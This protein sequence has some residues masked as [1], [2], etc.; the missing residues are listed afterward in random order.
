[1]NKQI[2]IITLNVPYPPDYG[3]IIDTF[4][5]IK[6]L[7][8]IGISIHLHCFEYGRG[9]SKELGEICETVN[10]YKRRPS[11]LSTWTFLPEI[12]KSRKSNKLLYNLI[13]D[14]HPILFD[15]LHTT[16][17]LNHPWL[18]DRKK[19][20]RAHNIEH[21][22]Y[23]NLSKLEPNIFKKIYFYAESKRLKRYER[24][25]SYA[26]HVLPISDTDFSYFSVKYNNAIQ[27]RPFHPFKDVESFPGFGNYVVYHGN[28]SIK[29]NELIVEK[30]IRNIFSQINTK[31][32]ITGKNPSSRL[33]NLVKQFP[34]IDLIPNPDKETINDIIKNAHIQLMLS[35][36]TTGFKV[37][38]LIALFSGR[39][40]VVNSNMIHG[41][42]LEE[43]CI[44]LNSEEEL[45]TRLEDLMD[46]EFTTE[47]IKKRKIFL[48]GIYNITENG[49]RLVDLI[50]NK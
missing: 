49:K 19:I 28:L 12:I 40:C 20:V 38:P 35:D 29:E 37:K 11:Y 4:Y 9:Y 3:G 5:R 22:Y 21:E 50:F 43:I 1:L 7:H 16:Y 2:H 23:L 36:T 18:R 6:T 13:A 44:V 41:T 32:V 47:M 34:T 24:I 10:C 45:A 17:L 15:G 31:F 39:H 14:K 46:K 42:G 30:L 26:D 25:L 48:S 8:E 33:K 27:I